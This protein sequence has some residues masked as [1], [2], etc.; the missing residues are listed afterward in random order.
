[1]YFSLPSLQHPAPVLYHIFVRVGEQLLSYYNK[2]NI[3]NQILNLFT[4]LKTTGTKKEL[5]LLK[6]PEIFPHPLEQ[7]NN[8]T[9]GDV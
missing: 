7:L 3:S 8:T 9:Q 4:N 1:M 6:F 2:Y 5:S